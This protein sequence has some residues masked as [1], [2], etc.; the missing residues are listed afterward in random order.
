MGTNVENDMTKTEQVIENAMA[1]VMKCRA[2]RER[3]MEDR[4]QRLA[5]IELMRVPKYLPK[6]GLQLDLPLN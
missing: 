1:L 3:E 6:G 4:R 2:A 5:R